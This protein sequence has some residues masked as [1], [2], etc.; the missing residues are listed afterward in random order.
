MPTRDR[1]KQ[2]Q[3]LSLKEK[4]AL[5]K[6]RI[7]EFYD[8]YDG[9]VIISFSGGKD[10]TVLVHLVR[11]LY[12]DVK[13]VYCDTGLEYPEV[14]DHV[15][16][17][18]NIEI[19]RPKIGFKEVLEKYGWCVPSKEVAEYIEAARNGKQWAINN[20]NGLDSKGNP[21][22]YKASRFS[23]HKYLLDAPFKIS[24]KCCEVMKKKP[25]KEYRKQHDNC[26]MFVGT[27]AEESVLRTNG[28]LK[29]G[30]N[31]FNRGK[32]MPLSFWTEND[33][34]LYIQS[35]YLKI[36]SVYGTIKR[37]I[38]GNYWTTGEERTGCIFCPIGCHLEM[39]PNKFERLKAL[40]PK[41]YDYALYKLGLSEVLDYIGVK[42]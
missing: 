34:L 23:R 2:L 39:H 22:S 11:S 10:S 24:A 36:P 35:Y 16:S 41:I 5:S 8:H 38:L 21:N 12:P 6:L 7:T 18:E 1:L 29:T 4:I 30:C 20:L 19:I 25:F 13:A 31:A 40:H 42:Y 37:G 32:G 33:I 27:L 15:K 3:E 17:F 26:G 14:K 9:N 28:W